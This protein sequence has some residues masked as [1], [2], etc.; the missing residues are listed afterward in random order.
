M[1]INYQFNYYI[2]TICNQFCDYCY[3]RNDFE[4]NKIRPTSQVLTELS[5]FKDFEHKSIITLIGGE[6][7]L[8]P[9][10]NTIM[11]YMYNN[12]QHHKLHLYTNGQF[13]LDR[14]LPTLDYN[15]LW[16]FSYHGK[17]VKDEDKLI[18]NLKYF[19]ANDVDF[20]ITIIAQNE[21]SDE[22]I[23]FLKG[24]NLQAKVVITFMHDSNGH[25]PNTPINEK[26]NDEW[27]QTVH[28]NMTDFYDSEYFKN[29][30][31][32]KGYSCDY[33]EIDI[34]DTKIFADECNHKF[35][36]TFTKE[37]LMS[38][39]AFEPTICNRDLCVQDCAYLFPKKE[40]NATV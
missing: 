31:N 37:A 11:E 40:K 9:K 27:F 10:F 7:T 8:H 35:S 6:P 23:S 28:R 39:P 22:F 33:N 5:W 38:I 15:F 30:A 29:N 19:I 20:N 17:F 34:L 4:W 21:I 36:K 18:E 1:K 32:Y 25:K 24:N 3:A 2:D 16:T 26:F 14:I 12:L 13:S